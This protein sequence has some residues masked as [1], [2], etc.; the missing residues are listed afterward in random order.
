MCFESWK[1]ALYQKCLAMRQFPISHAVVITLHRLAIATISRWAFAT[2]FVL[3]PLAPLRGE[4]GEGGE[5]LGVRGFALST[6]LATECGRA[7]EDSGH[8]VVIG[9]CDRIEFVIV[10]TCATQR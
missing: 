3:A 8:R 9:P 6:R 4:G 10:A 7:P 5:G 2:S 1:A